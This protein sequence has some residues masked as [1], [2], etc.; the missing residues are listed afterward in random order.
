V[1]SRGSVFADLGWDPDEV[2]D[3][4]KLR[5]DLRGCHAFTPNSLEAMHY[6]RTDTIEAAVEALAEFVPLPVV[7]DGQ[8]GSVA[9]DRE[10][11]SIVRAGSV[12]VDALD[13][14]GAGDVFD[15]G[16]L[17]GTLAGWP[18]EQRLRMAN[19]CAALSVSRFGGALAAPGWGDIAAWHRDLTSHEG[20]LRENYEFLED[21]LPTEPLP[22]LAHAIATL[23]F[24]TAR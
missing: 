3:L 21:H 8:R 10:S 24:R 19:L 9:F 7:T 2:W 4:A 6:T 14:T 5:D 11:G 12:L 13:P 1:A 23:G 20:S 22:E 18:V 16:L 17:V 15:A